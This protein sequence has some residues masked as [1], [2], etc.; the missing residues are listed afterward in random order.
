LVWL[1]ILAF[2]MGVFFAIVPIKFTSRGDDARI[3]ATKA[4]IQNLTE[5][6]ERF[7]SDVGHYPTTDEG[8]PALW[9]LTAAGWN[10][11]YMARP[12][13]ND[14]WGRRY[15]YRCP[16]KHNA[17]AFDLL[18]VGRDG[19]EGSGDDIDNWTTGKNEAEY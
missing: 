5:A 17:G 12:V 16:G 15:V 1:L 14:P 8:L 2:L 11:P 18:S 13:T 19:R 7:R 4:E 10:G 9:S 6:L 3:A